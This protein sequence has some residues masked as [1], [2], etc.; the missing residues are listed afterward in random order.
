MNFANKTRFEIIKYLEKKERSVNEISN[1][2]NQEQSKISH[3]LIKLASCHIIEVK[4]EGKK[5]IYSLNKK[6]V[7]PLLKIVKKHVNYECY[8]CNYQ[9]KCKK[10]KKIQK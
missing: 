3:N 2:L 8:D 7:I 10:T 5:R 6:T 9:N 1:A 4:K